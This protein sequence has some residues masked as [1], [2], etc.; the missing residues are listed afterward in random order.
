MNGKFFERVEETFSN[1]RVDR[2]EHVR[3]ERAYI[4]MFRDNRIVKIS[5]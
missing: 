3:K 5:F 4:F 1:D 2:V